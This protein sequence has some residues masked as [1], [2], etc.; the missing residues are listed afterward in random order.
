MIEVMYRQT[1]LINQITTSHFAVN[2]LCWMI[3]VIRETVSWFLVHA[4]FEFGVVFG[5]YHT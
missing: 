4:G 5:D 2:C 3:T 1:R